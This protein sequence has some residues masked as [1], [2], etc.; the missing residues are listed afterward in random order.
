ML[1]LRPVGRLEVQ[2]L[3][4]N[5]TDSL[6]SIPAHV[7]TEFSYLRRC[8]HFSLAPIFAV[9][10]NPLRPFDLRPCSNDMSIET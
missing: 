5:A 3:V 2:I 4:D 1:N 6:S 8:V 7:E 10:D 9:S